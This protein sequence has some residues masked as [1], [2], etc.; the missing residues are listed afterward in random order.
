LTSR[1]KEDVQIQF[2]NVIKMPSIRQEMLM[3]GMNESDLKQEVEPFLPHIVFFIERFGLF[4][5]PS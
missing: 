1:S 2:E 3:L 5:F 4:G